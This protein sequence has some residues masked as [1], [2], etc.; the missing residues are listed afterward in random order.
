MPT[1][2]GPDLGAL[3]SSSFPSPQ[4]LVK[5]SCTP[6]LAREV[7]QVKLH[8]KR[9]DISFLGWALVTCWLLGCSLWQSEGRKFLEKQ[10]LEFAATS[11]NNFLEYQSSSCSKDRS[12]HPETLISSGEFVVSAPDHAAWDVRTFIQEQGPGESQHFVQIRPIG[13]DAILYCDPIPLTPP[14]P[15]LTSADLEKFFSTN[16]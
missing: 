11:L 7:S 3:F 16:P 10:G 14:S 13:E 9:I 1:K 6:R 12:A 15:T 8:D 5:I 4:F 2:K